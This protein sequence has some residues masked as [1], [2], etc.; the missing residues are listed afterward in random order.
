MKEKISPEIIIWFGKFDCVCGCVCV[1][2]EY[3]NLDLHQ[4]NI[5][6]THYPAPV[7]GD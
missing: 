2:N 1:W 7:D 6:P 5:W 3:C 4:R